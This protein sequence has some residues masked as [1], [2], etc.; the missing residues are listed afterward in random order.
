MAGW[1]AYSQQAV[2][3]G[4]FDKATIIGAND[5]AN[6]G[7]SGLS[8]KPGEGAKIAALFKTPAQAF[9]E[10]IFVGGVKHLAVKSEGNSIYGKKGNGG[11]VCVK[12]NTAILVGLYPDGKSPGGAANA[13]EKVGDGLRDQGY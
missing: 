10:G 2:D 4:F 9:A 11:V 8:L 5:G 6:W 13:M 3:T 1:A 12:T 7:E